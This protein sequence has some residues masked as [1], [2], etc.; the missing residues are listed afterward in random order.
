M[1]LQAAVDNFVGVQQFAA[2]TSFGQISCLDLEARF[3]PTDLT[4]LFPVN[5]NALKLV[6]GAGFCVFGARTLFQGYPSQYIP[7]RRVLMKVEHDIKNLTQFA[8]FEPN[9]PS[10][11]ENITTVCNQYLTQQTLANL[12]GTTNPQTA[13]AV[14]CNSSNNSQTSAQAGYVFIQIQIALGSPVEI[15]VIN[16]AQ[17]TASAGTSTIVGLNT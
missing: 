12:L 3:T 4:A 10:L 13:F 17:L 11:W 16:I 14:T 6:P 15:M 8:M 5:I 1:G 9:V 2:G 7:I